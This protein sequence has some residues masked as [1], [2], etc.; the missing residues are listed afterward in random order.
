MSPRVGL[1]LDWEGAVVTGSER[2]AEPWSDVASIGIGVGR[3][4]T[5][6]EQRR[7]DVAR[8]ARERPFHGGDRL[9]ERLLLLDVVVGHDDEHRLIAGPVDRDGRERDG[10]CRVAVHRLGQHQRLG[11]QPANRLPVPASVTTTT[12]NGSMSGARR[13]AARSST[14]RPSV[15]VAKAAGSSRR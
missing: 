15:V 14:V 3:V 11:Q 13:V 2:L 1:A 4:H 12:S 9:A 7:G 5:E 10:G 8:G 6:R